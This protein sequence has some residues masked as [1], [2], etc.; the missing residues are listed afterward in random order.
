MTNKDI[1]K[2]VDDKGI[3]AAI[4]VDQRGALKRLLGEQGTDDNIALFKKLVSETFSP[5][6]S[7]ILL[8]PEYGKEGIQAKA[9]DAGLILAYEQTGYDKSVVG[10]LPRLVEGL[11]VKQLK[12]MG[13][14]GIKLLIYYDVDE[15]D[16]I[17]NVKKDLVQQVGQETVEEN[18]PFL[19]EIL[20]YDDQIG[21]VKGGSFAKVRPHKVIEAMKA[22]SDE[23]YNVDVLKV[24]TPVNIN[25]VEGFAEEYVFSKDEAASYFK[26]QE[27]ATSIPYIYLSGGLTSQQFKDTL[28]FA[29]ESGAHFNGVL[30]GRA[31][32]Q[33]GT[34][35]LKE[36]GQEAAKE[37]LNSEGIHNLETL[38]NIIQ[39]TATPIR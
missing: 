6:G 9:K 26:E 29:H 22:F 3:F 12:E 20:T 11:S 36:Q 38:N 15:P 18:I 5:S 34:V 4:A 8:D 19:L 35:V 30:C 27:T 24:E 32:W 23:K 31:T 2:L 37:W 14:D 16:D 33:G 17:N 13:A 10:R 25:Y 21:D 7:S 1:N 39:K 28:V